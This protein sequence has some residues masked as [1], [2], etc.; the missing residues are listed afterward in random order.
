MVRQVPYL[1]ILFALYYSNVKAAKGRFGQMSDTKISKAS[2]ISISA[3]MGGF[4]NLYHERI[5]SICCR[6]HLSSV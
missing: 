5:E 2:F 1:Q 4:M 3:D 6:L